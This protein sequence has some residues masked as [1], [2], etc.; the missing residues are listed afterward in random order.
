MDKKTKHL[1]AS[2]C[3]ILLMLAIVIYCVFQMQSGGHLFIQAKAITSDTTTGEESQ[4]I[5]VNDIIIAV[6]NEYEEPQQEHAQTEPTP[7]DHEWT[8]GVC[9]I[10]GEKCRHLWKNG[11]CRVCGFPCPHEQHDGDSKRCYQCGSVVCHHYMDGVCT[12]CNEPPTFYD[13]ILPIK[14]Y[15]QSDKPGKILTFAYGTTLYGWQQSMV[16]TAKIYLPYGYDQYDTETKYNVILLIHGGGDNKNCWLETVYEYPFATFTMRDIYDNMIKYHEA[17]PFI[18][19]SIDTAIPWD[20]DI[21]DTGD[22]QMAKEIRETIMPY[23][24]EHFHTYAADGSLESLQAARSHFAVGGLSNGSLYALNSGL[25]KNFDIFG[26]FACFSGNNA[27]EEVIK[28]V[29]KEEFSDLPIY[30]FFAGAGTYDG[31]LYRTNHGYER[32]L[33]ETDRLAD[34][35]NAFYQDVV[36]AHE[37]KVWSTDLFNAIPLLFQ[38]LSVDLRQYETTTVDLF[39]TET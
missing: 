14:F 33:E 25:V 31:Q 2:I 22:D 35:V 34:G 38:D 15:E 16:K 37:W 17:D 24:A 29:A 11:K 8:D 30:C 3:L 28:T 21:L 4:P 18:V 13:D 39:I 32:I 27:K 36:G 12:L 6:Q 20:E 7:C 26:S 19:V 10:C 1:A 23:V 5:P 9:S